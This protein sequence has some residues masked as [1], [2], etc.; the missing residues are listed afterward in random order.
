[1]LIP[2][3]IW[4][5][6][7]FVLVALGFADTPGDQATAGA[8]AGDGLPEDPP[9][10]D[11]APPQFNAYERRQLLA[12]ARRVVE[13]VVRFGELPSLDDPTLPA[14]AAV[15]RGCFVT[16]TRRGQ[17]RGCI[18]NLFPRLP[19]VQALAEN[20]RAAALED[21]RFERVTPDELPDL[22][23]EISVLTEPRPLPFTSPNELL[24]KLRP[25]QDGVILR[26]GAQSATFLPQVW[27]K[28]P[29]KITF[30]NHLAGKAGWSSDAWR[31]PGIEVQVYQAEA[32]AEDQGRQ[33]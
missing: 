13:A 2:E 31:Q 4:L 9:Q 1:M 15:P 30:L 20:A 21:R 7:L 18:G 22:I 29:D 16:L 24:A 32:F 27:A 33:M 8:T 12:L 11:V 25:H 23:I 28:L 5:G 14:L 26:R 6:L 17:V 3:A 19:L 10:S